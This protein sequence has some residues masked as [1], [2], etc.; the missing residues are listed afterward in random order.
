MTGLKRYG[1]QWP[2]GTPTLTLVARNNNGAADE[3]RPT[4]ILNRGDWLK[5]GQEV[6]V[7][8]PS[9]LHQLLPIRMAAAWTFARFGWWIPNRPRPRGYL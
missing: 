3:K 5:P 1:K 8:V 9:F 7:G 4:R 2:E 6:Q